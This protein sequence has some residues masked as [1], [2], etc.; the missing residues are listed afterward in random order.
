M[1]FSFVAAEKAHHSV[2]RLCAALSLSPSGF[3]AWQA[4]RPSARVAQDQHLTRQLRLVHADS[5]GTYG[6][7][8]LHQMLVRR[9]YRVSAKRLARLMREARLVARGRRR[10]CRTTVSDP[11][12]HAANV[13]ARQ[14]QVS[15][16]NTVWA[17]DITA[18]PTR[19]GWCYLAVILDLA[20]RRIVGWATRA[21]LDAEIAAGAL[22]SAM[23]TRAVRPGLLH[24]SD[25][26]VQ[27]TS[28]A[29]GALLTR[30]GFRVSMSRVGNCWD[31][32]PVESFFSS[33]KAE[34]LP[35]RLWLTRADAQHALTAYVRFYNERRLH[36][37]LGFQSP[38][39]YE[40]RL[41]AVV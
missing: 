40:A 11:A 12:A 38:Q 6:R 36:S 31:N 25:R 15:R 37:S 16:V 41:A 1:T 2:R 39:E 23:A 26:G 21:T 3:Y 5:R 8:R 33:L 29:Y 34:V 13:L 35:D 22:R 30:A 14:F 28:A 19:E 18:L 27:Y 17:A 20:S 9:G 7:P 32:A 4:R 24:H 10:G